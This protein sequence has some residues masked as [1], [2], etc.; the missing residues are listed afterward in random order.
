MAAVRLGY[1]IGPASLIADLDRVV[2]P[3]HLSALTQ[4]AG[5]LALKYRAE[6]E[7]RVATIVE[8]RGRLAAAFA[9]MPV[10]A[11]PSDANFILFRPQGR[12]GSEVWKLL[13]DND[14]LVRDCNSWPGLENCLRVTV[15]TPS[16]NDA[17]LAALKE[18]LT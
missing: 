15:G 8:E 3:Y 14:V 17:F 6:M 12:D 4:A 13:V 7:A 16:E 2:L 10:E 11:W 18:A 5:L 9:D 1:L